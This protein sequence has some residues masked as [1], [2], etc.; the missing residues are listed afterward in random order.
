MAKLRHA[1]RTEFRYSPKLTHR[2]GLCSFRQNNFVVP[3]MLQTS[4]KTAIY[5]TPFGLCPFTA[6]CS[7]PSA[8]SP[9]MGFWPTINAL[10]RRVV[11]RFECWKKI[12]QTWSYFLFRQITTVFVDERSRRAMPDVNDNHNKGRGRRPDGCER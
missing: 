11:D 12:G 6:G 3:A 7:S 4:A 8:S 9:L 10:A 2:A 5:I 1:S